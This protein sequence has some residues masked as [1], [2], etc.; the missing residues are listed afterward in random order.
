MTD[1]AFAPLLVY[2]IPAFA[3]LLA[4]ELTW[5]AT[6][7]K[8]IGFNGKDAFTSVIMGLGMTVSDILMGA[9]SLGILYFFW[10]FRFF[11]LGYSLPI[12]ILAFVVGDFKYYWKHRFFHRMRFWWMS[13]NVHHSSEHYNISTALRQPW[14]N[15]IGL[16]AVMGIPMVLLGF[17]PL[18]VAF[19]GALNLLYQFWIHTELIDKLPKWFEAVMNTPSHHRVHHGR[20]PQY[21]D[22]NYAGTFIIWDRM[23][24]TFIAED[25]NDPVDY[26]L[27][28]PMTTY[29]PFK[30]AFIEMAGIIKD[31]AQPGLTPMQRFKYVFAPP[32]YS[33]DGSRMSSEMIKAQAA[34]QAGETTETNAAII[35]AK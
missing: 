26:G 3:A 20:N 29:N 25:A 22:S 15:H 6:K 16:H 21:L 30:V 19:V 9:L 34:K 8:D 23:F 27:V 4:L 24:G 1:P 7:R 10:Q 31:A 13:H 17:H 5:L 11:D 18:L 33:H 14:T 35:R 12:I 28:T 32:G 2:A